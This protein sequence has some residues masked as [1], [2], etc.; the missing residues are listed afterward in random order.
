MFEKR[1]IVNMLIGGWLIHQVTRTRRTGVGSS[2]DPAYAGPRVLVRARVE[3]KQRLVRGAEGKE[4]I[5][6]C[7]M[8]LIDEPRYDDIYWLPS[9]A[10]SVADLVTD[11]DAGRSPVSIAGAT[12]KLG[13]Q[14]LWM[15]YFG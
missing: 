3:F 2:A 6:Q 1:E 10:G 7:E 15:V 9:I 14:R 5:S 4:V 11:I 12:N 8:A 13:T